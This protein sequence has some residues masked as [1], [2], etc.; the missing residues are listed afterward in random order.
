MP[1]AH[2][3]EFSA[4]VHLLSYRCGVQV[5]HVFDKNRS[6]VVD[7]E[8]SRLVLLQVDG[9]RMSPK[10]NRSPCSRQHFGLD[11]GLF[12]YMERNLVSVSERPGGGSMNER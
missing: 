8:A 10:L 5:L 7:V 11:Q 6:F 9:E 12:A 3:L 1:R 2:R 4:T